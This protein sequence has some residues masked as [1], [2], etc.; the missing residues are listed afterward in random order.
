MMK[1]LN[2][3][4]LM[5]FLFI[6]A[7]V[8]FILGQLLRI[9]VSDTIFILVLL[10]LFFIIV[11]IHGWKTLGAWEFLVFFL[12]AFSIPLLYEYTD[13]LGVGGL[14]GCTVQYSELLGPK[15]GKIPYVIP[16]TWA[17]FIYCGFTMTNIIFNRIRTTN[18]FEEKASLQ[19]FMRLVGMGIVA[20]LIAAAL[21]LLVDPMMVAMGAWSWSYQGSYYGIPLW[22]YEGWVEI[23][24]VT[25][26]LFSAYL[27]MMK[28]SQRFIGG[29]ERSSYTLLV[30][31]LY[32]AAFLVFVVF[33]VYEQVL[34]VILWAAIAVGSFAVVTIV[35]FYRSSPEI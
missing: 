33:A 24:A 4:Q 11:V 20:G 7:G 34:P 16:L 3:N 6:C 35:R 29:E 23:P 5:I 32:L 9:P 1:I 8:F 25:F 15:I 28:R 19:W 18:T 26:V 31:V 13:A 10:L 27:N 21:D 12:I 14:V 17:M 2:S 22:N 30:V